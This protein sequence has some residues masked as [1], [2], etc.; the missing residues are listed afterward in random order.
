MPMVH[1]E[2]P[3][4]ARS[5]SDV[6]QFDRGAEHDVSDR[7]ATGR[8]WLL[9]VEVY[10]TGNQP[11]PSVPEPYSL[12]SR[13]L[14]LAPPS[15]HHVEHIE[16]KF[17]TTRRACHL[18]LT[19]VFTAGA[20]LM[21]PAPAAAK[22]GEGGGSEGGHDQGRHLGW[23]KHGGPG[24]IDRGYSGYSGAWG[25]RR[26][27]GGG[28][29]G[30][31]SGVIASSAAWGVAWGLGPRF[32]FYA[33]PAVYV[34]L[35]V[36]VALPPVVVSVPWLAAPA[37]YY[38][39][40]PVY[41][42]PV[43][44]EPT[45]EAMLSATVPPPVMVLPPPEVMVLA[46]P[47]PVIFSPPAYALSVWPVLAFAPPMLAVAVLHD[48]WWTTR[49]RGRGGYYAGGFYASQGYFGG[50]YGA[51]AWGPGRGGNAGGPHGHA[52]NFSG[53]PGGPG[54]AHGGGHEDGGGH[55]SGRGHGGGGRQGN[56]Q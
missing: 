8:A 45:P 32:A 29:W 48:D 13:P 46:A 2:R 18:L 35:P 49:Y 44:A 30:W 27:S 54:N 11:E 12:P 55:G 50:G 6:E 36:Y 34:P 17:F 1:C 40:P 20:A 28:A 24:S 33:P 21:I 4:K 10:S 41:A 31:Q 51:S 26:G 38:A 5:A 3:G 52:V 23:Y 15:D 7:A 56:N 16:V 14:R 25:E 9:T 53:S 37:P 42:A 39:P 47:P 22:H 19:T 43:A